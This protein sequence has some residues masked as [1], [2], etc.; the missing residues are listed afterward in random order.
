MYHM[1]KDGK[2]FRQVEKTANLGSK[3]KPT[4]CPSPVIVIMIEQPQPERHSVATK[5]RRYE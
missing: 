4:N 1:M 5:L 3:S 2:A